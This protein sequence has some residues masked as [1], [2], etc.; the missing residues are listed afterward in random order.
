MSDLTDSRSAFSVS[1]KNSRNATRFVWFRRVSRS[2][3]C[4][5]IGVILDPLPHQLDVVAGAGVSGCKSRQWRKDSDR[6]LELI[7]DSP[8]ACPERLPPAFL[9]PAGGL[10]RRPGCPG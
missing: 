4:H 9:P 8:G 1:I 2:R 7:E 10:L 5:S 3:A 6:G